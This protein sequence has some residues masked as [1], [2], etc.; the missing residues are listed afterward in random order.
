LKGGKTKK[1]IARKSAS[2]DPSSE[3]TTALELAWMDMSGNG[4]T[5][6]SGGHALG[7]GA[8]T[9]IEQETKQPK[10]I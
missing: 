3:K 7:I 2:S 4:E 5:D 1:G 6:Q 9:Q 10:M 8:S